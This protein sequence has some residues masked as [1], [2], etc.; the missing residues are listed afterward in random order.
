MNEVM[1]AWCVQSLHLG[2]GAGPE[3][4]VAGVRGHV[5]CYWSYCLW[6][7]PADL[8]GRHEDTPRAPGPETRS[9]PL[10]G[11]AGGPGTRSLLRARGCGSVPSLAASST[12]TSSPSPASRP[13]PL[14]TAPRGHRR[15]PAP[16][17]SLLTTRS[18]V[19]RAREPGPTERKSSSPW[20]HPW[21]REAN[22]QPA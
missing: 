10:P 2:A 4:R 1:P 21:N 19:R 7:A 9:G 16:A 17:P 6:R 15:P 5:I 18:G 13:L 8:G 22:L 20:G 12:F 14:L 3:R 11:T